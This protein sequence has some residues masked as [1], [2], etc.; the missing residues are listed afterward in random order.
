MEAANSIQHQNRCNAQEFCF[1]TG[2]IAYPTV[3]I[4][5][6]SSALAICRWERVLLYNPPTETY[7]F[8][9]IPFDIAKYR[10]ALHVAYLA[11][12]TSHMVSMVAGNFIIIDTPNEDDGAQDM[13]GTVN[14]YAILGDSLHQTSFV[15]RLTGVKNSQCEIYLDRQY[16]EIERQRA[17]QLRRLTAQAAQ[18]D[19]EYRVMRMDQR[20][21]QLEQRKRQ[22]PDLD[23]T[24]E[25]KMMSQSAQYLRYSPHDCSYANKSIHIPLRRTSKSGDV[26]P[27]IA[28]ARHVMQ[29]RDIDRQ[30][31]EIQARR[32]LVTSDRNTQCNLVKSVQFAHVE[33]T[34]QDCMEESAGAFEQGAMPYIGYESFQSNRCQ[35][36]SQHGRVGP[37]NGIKRSQSLKPPSQNGQQSDMVRSNYLRPPYSARH[38]SLTSEIDSDDAASVKS[39]TDYSRYSILLRTYNVDNIDK[40]IDSV[41]EMGWDD[42]HTSPS[43]KCITSMG[44]VK[45]TPE[46]NE[47]HRGR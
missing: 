17:S 40:G 1:K 34:Q 15:E 21:N 32:Q 20:W 39:D 46:Q 29:L 3:H 23:T 19:Y 12:D 11:T 38:H 22:N 5:T 47:A 37:L 36:S 14:T 28:K 44:Q 24:Y 31:E 43:P 4:C 30:V 16:H 18:V 7:A 8:T 13:K 42:H 35:Q 10:R 27:I 26:T 33:D 6:P 45:V 25:E 9:V 2:C 41:S